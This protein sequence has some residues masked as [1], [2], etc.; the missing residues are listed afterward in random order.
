MGEVDNGSDDEVCKFKELL[1]VTDVEECMVFDGD[2]GEFDELKDKRD[3][4]CVHAFSKL[5]LSSS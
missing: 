1:V 4:E 3:E 5:L 2:G